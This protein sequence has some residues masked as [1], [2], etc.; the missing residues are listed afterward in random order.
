M[1]KTKL[2]LAGSFLL[3]TTFLSAQ[4]QRTC[5][6]EGFSNAS[7]GPCA[8]QNP[9]YNTLLGN[10]TTKVIGI[11]YQT[12]WPG[13]D[14]MNAQTQSQVGTRVSY[15]NVT[16]VPWG[17]LDGTAYAGANYSGALA[18]LD[19]TEIDTRY[20]TTS[21]FSLNITHS[22]SSDLDSVFISVSVT[23]P[24]AFSGSNLKL[25][26]NMVEETIS[27]S[28]A[29]G[30][31]GETVF[32]SVFRNSYTGISGQTIQNSWAS[33]ENQVYTFAAPVPAY[34]YDMTQVA[35]VAFIQDNGTKEVHQ[36]GL[37]LPV[38][39]NNY[40]VTQNI[41][42]IE[43]LSCVGDLNNITVDIDNIG[44]N[45]MT[46]C[47]V[48]YQI[49][50]GTPQTASWT[51]T[52]ASGNT[53]TFTLPNM[54]GISN[55][56]HTLT[57]W[58]TNINNS[59]STSPLGTATKSFTIVSANGSV[60]PITQDFSTGPLPYTN[61]AL[62][63]PN[64]SY[65]W[66]RV[67][68]AGGAAVFQAYAFPN[69]AT[70]GMILE[71]VDMNALGTGVNLTFDVAYRQYSSE[72]DRLQVYVSTDC[73]AT[74][75]NVYNKAGSTLATLSASTTQYIPSA[76][77]PSSDWR[78]ESIDLSAYSS[79][80]KLFVKFQATSNYGNNL[81]I[82]N[83]NLSS[84]TFGVE[85]N[86]NVT[87]NLYPNPTADVVNLNLNLTSASDVTV[88]VVNYLGQ[89]IMVRNLGN[90]NGNTTT[91]LDVSSLA[92]GVYNMTINTN[93]RISVKSFIKE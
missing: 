60:S 23:T 85:E 93:G 71:P 83:I 61:W 70:S 74:W 14:P 64:P 31:N 81:W 11:K 50:S 28:S 19:Q 4:V 43:P 5:L 53:T 2:L 79:A 29:P 18:N 30:S 49:D 57:T 42:N 88:S 22:L 54:T 34:I 48:N 16:G 90:M 36:A 21:P 46:S 10:N 15:Y 63:N 68:N 45:T 51:G 76:A 78:N 37:S 69:N 41:D 13:T 52:I 73:G 32:H 56:A 44:G 55:G 40:A 59:G 26:V 24:N 39:I 72:N 27:F 89:T 47:T 62:D 77:A 58:L 9:N 25:H 7:C 84:G 87:M 12:N 67:T 8:A 17:A 91:Q 86:G 20:G 75:V 66:A 6:A 35:I 33:A 92:P 80:N 1:K 82:D 38:A 3:S 65:S